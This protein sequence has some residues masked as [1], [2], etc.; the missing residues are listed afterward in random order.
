[1]LMHNYNS[2]RTGMSETSHTTEADRAKIRAKMARALAMAGMEGVNVIS[3][4]TAEQ[5]LTRRRREILRAIKDEQPESVRALART[6]DRDKGAVSRDLT[7]LCKAGV[8][9]YEQDGRAKR[10]VLA[11]E[12]L[13]VEPIV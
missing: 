2:K 10:P 1:M 11:Q 5:V 7:R 3:Q 9:T 12:H 6:L 13:V 8:V 4:R